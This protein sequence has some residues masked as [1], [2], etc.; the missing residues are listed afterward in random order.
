MVLRTLLCWLI[1]EI[2]TSASSGTEN[3]QLPESATQPDWPD[4][5]LQ[6]TPAQ[7]LDEIKTL[8]FMQYAQR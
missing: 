6:P 3:K 8:F 1:T 4:G 2:S 7:H 5:T